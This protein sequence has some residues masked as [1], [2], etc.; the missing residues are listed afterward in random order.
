MQLNAGSRWVESS[1]PTFSLIALKFCCP[2]F[3][4][5]WILLNFYPQIKPELQQ[6]GHS[7]P[8]TVRSSLRSSSCLGAWKLFWEGEEGKA[9]LR[10]L[11]YGQPASSARLAHSGV[12]NTDSLLSGMLMPADC[13]AGPLMFVIHRSISAL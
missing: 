5:Y 8:V 13:Q 10:Q 12:S 11:G 1:F 7:S 2:L 4:L 6:S 3:F 9:L